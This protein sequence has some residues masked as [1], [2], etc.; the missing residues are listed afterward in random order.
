MGPSVYHWFQDSCPTLS[1]GD[2][3]VA[4]HRQAHHGGTQRW[5]DTNQWKWKVFRQLRLSC[6]VWKAQVIHILLNTLNWNL[7][8]I[9]C[10]RNIE[11]ERWGE[12]KRR[13]DEMRRDEKK[14]LT[15]EERDRHSPLFNLEVHLLTLSLFVLFMSIVALN[16][17]LKLRVNQ[18][19]QVCC[20]HK[21]R[22]HRDRC[23]VGDASLMLRT[24]ASCHKVW[25]FLASFL[26][27]WPSMMTHASAIAFT[28]LPLN[29]SWNGLAGFMRKRDIF[30]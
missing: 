26:Y 4:E 5:H 18:R 30:F 16:Q 2:P 10:W 24:A 17:E 9:W 23:C 22:L 15:N 1:P 27:P 13:W 28:R 20:L 29:S 3:A 19:T 14:P 25:C 11:P 6:C 7:D 21:W 12:E 8:F